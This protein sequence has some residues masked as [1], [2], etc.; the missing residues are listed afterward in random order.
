[1]TDRDR[2]EAQTENRENQSATSQNH[3]A[4]APDQGAGAWEGYSPAILA[5]VLDA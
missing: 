3:E 1:M 4:S 2:S 5:A